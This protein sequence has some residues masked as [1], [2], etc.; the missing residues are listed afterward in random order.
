MAFDYREI[1]P[2]GKLMWFG[3]QKVLNDFCDHYKLEDGFPYLYVLKLECGMFYI[4]STYSIFQRMKQHFSWNY[5]NY[6]AIAQRFPVEYI[7]EIIPLRDERILLYEDALTVEYISKYGVS[8]VRGGHF[9]NPDIN[10]AYGEV[11]LQRFGFICVNNKLF[12][13]RR[14]IN[15]ALYKLKKMH[16]IHPVKAFIDG[17]IATVERLLYTTAKMDADESNKQTDQLLLDKVAT[18]KQ[19]A[20]TKSAEHHREDRK[21]EA[22]VEIRAAQR[23]IVQYMVYYNENW[24][25][26]EK[27]IIPE[28]AFTDE[29]YR[30]VVT[31]FY[32]SGRCDLDE[33]S[34]YFDT[35]DE[36]DELNHI[37]QEV[38][39]MQK[40]TQG[41]KE[42]N[43]LTECVIQV[44]RR[45]LQ[46]QA[47]ETDDIQRL[48]EL[49]EALKNLKTLNL[50]LPM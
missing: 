9:T 50:S 42:R 31:V 28:E 8:S 43:G 41:D 30:K 6:V 47:D 35:Q 13:N 19:P 25:Q 26:T 24:I 14:A 29:I 48:Q 32:Q 22:D 40:K 4:G 23:L 36:F 10:K 1:N 17:D 45:Y 7:L 38:D 46:K 2:E 39:A 44:M 18:Y 49:M 11:N 15:T 37:L 21:R 16:R 5:R 12:T 34:A 33:L 20:P 3:T 27:N